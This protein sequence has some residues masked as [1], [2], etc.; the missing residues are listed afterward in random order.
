MKYILILACI[1]AIL[2]FSVIASGQ[3]TF[4]SI[5]PDLALTGSSKQSNNNRGTGIG[6]SIRLESSWSKHISGIATVG[7]LSFAK[8]SPYPFSPTYTNQVNVIPIQIGIKYYT[9]EK[10]L[11]PHGV[12]FSGE[13]GIM[14]TSTNIT[15][16]NETKTNRKE[17]GFSTAFGA[18]YQYRRLESS[19]RLQ[20]NLSDSGFDVYYYNFRI[21]YSLFKGKK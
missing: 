18:G 6:G 4:V 13:I 17:N 5:G 11:K 10:N 14:P 16:T 1:S 12:F 20:Y 2:L 8:R 21:A 7:Y 15:F 19:F 9:Q 3:K